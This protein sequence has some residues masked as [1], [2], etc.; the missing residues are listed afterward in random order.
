[1]F[2]YYGSILSVNFMGTETKDIFKAII[3]SNGVQK[4]EMLG[5]S[6]YYKPNDII[7]KV[8][9]RLDHD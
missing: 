5:V 3:D 4:V 2:F 9:A 8:N 1:M 7:V 6:Y